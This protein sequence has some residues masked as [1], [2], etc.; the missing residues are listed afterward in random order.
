M[1]KLQSQIVTQTFCG[2]YVLDLIDK[3]L[4][5]Y[6]IEVNIFLYIP[7]LNSMSALKT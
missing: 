2:H 4:N 6:H 3:I 7:D 5:K 1:D